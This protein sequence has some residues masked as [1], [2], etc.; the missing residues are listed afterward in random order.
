MNNHGGAPI[1]RAADDFLHTAQNIL[2]LAGRR[3]VPA[4]DLVA[5]DLDPKAQGAGH[6]AGVET[7]LTLQRRDRGCGRRIV[8]VRQF[9]SDGIETRQPLGLIRQRGTLADIVSQIGV[10]G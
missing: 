7:E 4:H 9:S 3:R 10:G 2:D 6:Q 1:I 8:R 5:A